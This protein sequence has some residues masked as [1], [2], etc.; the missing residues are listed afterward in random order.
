MKKPN[1]TK[2]ETMVRRVLLDLKVIAGGLMLLYATSFA[3]FWPMVSVREFFPHG[4]VLAGVFGGLFAA[5]LAAFWLKN[6]GRL[7][8]VYLNMG[9]AYYLMGLYVL[10]SWGKL[11]PVGYFFMAVIVAL[12][13]NQPKTRARFVQKKGTSWR[14]I[15]VIDDDE[16]VCRIIRP[17]L[18]N[19]GYSVLTALTGEEG[20]AIARQQKP[21]LILLDVIL[22]KMKGREVCKELKAFPETAAIPVI[23]LT[24]KDSDDDVEAELAAG[25]QAHL[26][27]PVDPRVLL[28]TVRKILN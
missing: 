28:A 17:I 25:A 14:S 16:I 24:A 9:F 23:F 10:L 19:N 22:P 20:L 26:T 1:F 21:D 4:A 12:F 18:M 5:S 2:G 13:F 15:L 27:K 6:W 3:A 7:I 11:I 8:L